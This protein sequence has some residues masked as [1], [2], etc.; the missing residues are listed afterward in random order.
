MKIL[1]RV[2]DLE[3]DQTQDIELPDEAAARAWLVARPRMREVL[4]VP[5]EGVPIEVSH[6][7][8]AAMRPLDADEHEAVERL[9]LA[10]KQEMERQ[11]LERKLAAE[12]ADA[13]EVKRLATADP[14]RPMKL[15]WTYKGELT[16]LGGDPR[17][18]NEDVLAAVREWVLERNTWVEGRGQMVGEATID[19]YPGPVP[20]GQERVME[21]GRF[22]PVTKG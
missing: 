5:S 14:N 13:E 10:R 4:G 1:L 7:L 3:T 12:R 18:P 2:R 16:V 9:E 6:A 20:K 19:V 8:K 17:V 22:V 15:R 21:G 11:A